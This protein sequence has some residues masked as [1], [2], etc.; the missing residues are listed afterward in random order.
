MRFIV[1]LFL[2]VGG[3]AYG[4]CD[5]STAE[6]NNGWGWDN[7]AKE[8]CPPLSDEGE[9]EVPPVSIRPVCE[10]P[11]ISDPDSD[12]YG[13][14]NGQTCIVDDDAPAAPAPLFNFVF[15]GDWSCRIQVIGYGEYVWRGLPAVDTNLSLTVDDTHIT[16]WYLRSPNQ[17]R[18]IQPWTMT[19]N[20]I[21][22]D[23]SIQ[24]GGIEYIGII[25]PDR[26]VMQIGAL[27]VEEIRRYFCHRL[28]I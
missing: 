20:G 17:P 1:V 22:S 11:G 5:Y 14:E 21:Q 4:A 25:T 27:R 19:E 15:Q 3:A 26:F 28:S 10:F 24:S 12:G 2:L 9:P 7:V 18:D 8:S 6:T 13:W 16:Y 23:F